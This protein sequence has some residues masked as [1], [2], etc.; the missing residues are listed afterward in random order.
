MLRR[1]EP[2]HALVVDLV[3]RGTQQVSDASVAKAP[4]FMGQLDY[5]LARGQVVLRT[6]GRMPPAV[7]RQTH[8]GAGAPLTD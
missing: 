8:Q 6:L 5:A 7:A 3:A 1:V 4:T 2:V